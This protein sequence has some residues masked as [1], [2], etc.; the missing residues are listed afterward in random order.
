MN[1]RE[2][3]FR[4]T[5][6]LTKK[7]GSTPK[8]KSQNAV[9]CT[10]I[11]SHLFYFAVACKKL[12]SLVTLICYDQVPKEGASRFERKTYR[13]AVD[14]STTE[15]YTQRWTAMLEKVNSSP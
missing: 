3:D 15:L 6:I 5:R 9:P 14:C 7:I 10:K 11:H 4:I 1:S 8:S 13:S 12:G 2:F